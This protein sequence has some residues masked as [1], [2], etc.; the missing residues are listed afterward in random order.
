MDIAVIGCGY[1][2][3]K[4]A[5]FWTGQNHHVTATTRHP[6]KLPD[7]AKVAQKTVLFRE[8]D[9]DTLSLLLANHE[10]LVVTIGADD[11][12]H[13][14]EAYLKT[15]QMFRSLALE[16]NVP[17]RLLYTSSTSVYG[18]AAG[19]W[20]DES[21]PLQGGSETN[22]I[23][24]ETEKTYLS[25]QELGW[26][27]VIFRLAELYGPERTLLQKIQSFQ[28]K[29]LPGDGTQY[30]NMI[31][32]DDVV[33]AL[34]YALKHPLEG[35]YNLADDDHPLRKDL[36]EKVASKG[37][38]PPVKWDPSLSGLRGGSKRVSNHKLKAEGF[39]LLHPHR[40]F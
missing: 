11:L 5:S 39:H 12:A 26:S 23:L 3:R 9:L 35:I 4:A 32:R 29:E 33:H 31:H 36:Y 27:V 30:A 28:G 38:L 15:A 14:E 25:L 24:I 13:Y 37:G 20:V 34:D 16:M 18:D 19:Q 10:A 40:V 21:T 22:R 1:L 7:L 8:G 2:G 6:E 17:R